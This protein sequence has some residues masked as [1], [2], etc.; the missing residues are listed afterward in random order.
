MIFLFGTLALVGA[1]LILPGWIWAKRKSEQNLWLFFLPA[2]G[3][4]LWVFLTVVGVG[5]QSLSNL[6]ETLGVVV[7]A[8]IAAYLKFLVFDRKIENR[9]QGTA[10][11]FVIVVLATVAFRLFTPH[12]PE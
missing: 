5:A 12:L 3:I 10:V 9:T 4:G 11:A 8:V 7:V 6:S 1:A 2:V